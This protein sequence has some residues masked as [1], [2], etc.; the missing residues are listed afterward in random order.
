MEQKLRTTTPVDESRE[1]GCS[2]RSKEHLKELTKFSGSI[3]EY[4]AFCQ[5]LNLC[6][7]RERFRD[8]K[9]KALFVYRYLTGSARDLVTHFIRP[10][11]DDSCLSILNRLEWT[12]GGERNLDRLLIKKLHKLPKLTSF[13]LDSLIHMIVTIE[14]AIPALLR[15]EP[16]S[17]T[18]EDGERFNRLLNLM[19]QIEIDFFLDFCLI[20]NRLQNLK[21]LLNFLKAK[22]EA[23]R[24]N[25][26]HDREK[27]QVTSCPTRPTKEKTTPGKYLYYQGEVESE[28][29][30]SPEENVMTRKTH[31]T[32]LKIGEPRSR[33]K[34]RTYGPCG[35]CGGSHTLAK[36]QAFRELTLEEKRKVV[37]EA[38]ACIKCLHVGHFRR[39]C[40]VVGK[41]S[42]TGCKEA[43]HTLLH[44]DYVQQVKFFEE[45]DDE[46]SPTEKKV[47]PVGD[48]SS[49]EP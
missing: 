3:E 43:H 14:S 16:E 33:E 23:R 17:V 47:P 30:S 12:Y 46:E 44:D 49:E 31:S 2:Y 18:A 48:S 1:W 7:E 21:G 40:Q 28:T 22:F 10:L 25:M 8:E 32:V 41:C 38:K 19:P 42:H 20:R 11:G 35:K 13:T 37:R 5:H 9:D 36:C 27:R 34:P 26:P 6:L 15:R 4:P 24:N 39:N 45:L 29:D